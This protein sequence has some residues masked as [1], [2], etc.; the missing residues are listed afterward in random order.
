MIHKYNENK[1]AIAVC[2]TSAMLCGAVNAD[3]WKLEEVLVTAQK[4]EQSS[5]DIPISISAFN[6]ELMRSAQLDNAKELALV[7]P[8]VSG[9]SADSY[10]DAINIRGISSNSYGL[11]AESSVGIYAN[12]VYLGRAGGA[13]TSYFDIDRVEILK[14]PQGTLFG[15]NASAGAISLHTNKAVIDEFSGRVDVGVGS[16]GYFTTTGVLN[17]PLSDNLA[18]RMAIYRREVDGYFENVTTGERIGDEKVTAGRLSFTF[19]TESVTANLAMDY[20]DRLNPTVVDRAIDSSIARNE[21]RSEQSKDTLK[22][23][24]EVWGLSLNLEIAL[25][26]DYSLTSI[27]GARGHN[28]FYGEDFEASELD[29]Y[30]YIINQEQEYYSQEFRLD[31]QGDGPVSWFVG[32]SAYEEKVSALI[33]QTYDEDEMC[34]GTAIYYGDSSIT[35]CGSLYVYWGYADYG[36]GIGQRNDSADADGDYDGWGIYGDTTWN[37]TE[38]LELIVGARYTEDN[39]DFGLKLDSHNKNYFWYNWP[40]YSSEPIEDTKKWDNTSYRIALNYSLNDDILLYATVSTG[41]KAGGFE[42]FG[43]D[44]PASYDQESS[45]DAS[46]AGGRLSS[47]DQEEVINYEVGM[48]SEWWD[49]RIQF[50]TSTY[51]YQFEDMQAA[52]LQGASVTTKN[53]G[54]VDGSGLEIDL[55]ALPTE[56]INVYLGLA[57]ADSNLSDP[58]DDFC[59]ASGCKKGGRLPGDIGFSSAFIGTYTFYLSRG[60]TFITLE[61]YYQ[62][63]TTAY[64]DWSDTLI[65]GSYKET[66]MR[67]GYKSN[68]D[69]SITLWGTN[70]TDEWMEGDQS[71]RDF[72]LTDKFV[73]VGQ[74]PR[75]YGVDVKYEF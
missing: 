25:S 13:V 1:L 29:G 40:Y 56:N 54:E 23:Q 22:D 2:A 20:E 36:P 33:E 52:Y 34:A 63:E 37:V 35:D 74:Q 14:G 30:T 47:F 15:R 5:Q 16:D 44:M 7:T 61:N 6:G 66:N 4:R 53:V 27:T 32:V 49:N 8:G 41:Y 68:D 73:R 75:R 12:G 71:P 43:Y 57:W 58:N 69:W 42:T 24:G 45:V 65:R 26:E 55:R 72:N 48:K 28:Y 59:V 62:D 60:E 46:K 64:G 70:L 51:Y 18:S 50:N 10:L 39:R 9:N 17:T 21:I 3:A 67:I 31:Y 11:A 38:Q 19:K